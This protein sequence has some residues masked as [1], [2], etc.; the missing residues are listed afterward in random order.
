VIRG[1]TTGVHTG[2]F[3]GVEPTGKRISWEFVDMYRSGPD[4]RLSLRFSSS[5]RARHDVSFKQKTMSTMP[6][7]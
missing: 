5:R 6:Q 1:R 2:A 4:G 3:L 7:N